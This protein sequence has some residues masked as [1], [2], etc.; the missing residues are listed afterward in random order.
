[1]NEKL[2]N[3]LHGWGYLDL[4]T[5][6]MKFKL[7]DERQ[8]EKMVHE[9]RWQDE[10]QEVIS[11]VKANDKAHLSAGAIT[12]IGHLEGIREAEKRGEVV[13]MPEPH[14]LF[15]DVDSYEGDVNFYDAYD[16]M[17][18]NCYPDAKIIYAGKS[19]NSTGK[20]PYSKHYIIDIGF[21]LDNF[22]RVALQA[23]LNSDHRREI[24][25]LGR[26]LNGINNPTLFFEKREAADTI[27]EARRANS[28]S[29]QR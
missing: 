1:L 17:K 8:G 28:A 7:F 11:R 2:V 27:Y 20:K 18:M 4:G 22:Q 14:E 13:L 21:P 9:E 19:R 23:M 6:E 15:I 25:S 10:P 26:M 16:H 24:I 3:W 29:R 12:E 5:G